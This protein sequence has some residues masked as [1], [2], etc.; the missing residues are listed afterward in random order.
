MDGICPPFPILLGAGGENPRVEIFSTDSQKPREVLGFPSSNSVYAI[1][2]HLE[3]NLFA[4]GTKGGL[5]YIL[6]GVGQHLD[7]KETAWSQK[8]VQG[9]SILSVCWI[10]KDLLAVS[11]TAGRCFLWYLNT[12][13]PPQPL[14]TANGL[15][16]GLLNL[17]EDFLVGL[18]SGGTLHFWDPL[19]GNLVR[20]INIPHPPK[21]SGLVRFVHWP[22]KDALVFPAQK[23]CLTH[24]NIFSDSI[25]TMGAHSAEVYAITVEGEN[26]I[27]AGINDGQLKIWSSTSKKPACQIQSFKGIVS[28]EA[29]GVNQS[30][31][32]LIESGGTAGVFKI[33][34]NSLKLITRLAGQDYR[35]VFGPSLE[36]IKV[37][38]DQHR[39]A[40]VR[41]LTSQILGKN[42]QAP[43]DVIQNCYSRLDG[44]D[45]GHISLALQA[46]QAIEKKDIV[47]AIR[48]RLSLQNKLPHND[49]NALPSIKKYAD[50]LAKAWHIEEA[51]DAYQKIL[52]ID[53]RYPLDTKIHALRKIADILSIKSNWIIEPDIA[54]DQIIQSAEAIGKSFFGRF[55]IKKHKSIQCRHANIS[56][57]RIVKKYEQI[58]KEL[59][60]KGLPPAVKEKV[61]WISQAGLEKV[62]IITF[63]N[64][65]DNCIKGLQ[66]AL[67]VINSGLAIVAIPLILFDWPDIGL[68]GTTEDRNESALKHLADI[69]TKVSSNS[70]LAMIHKTVL[71]AL[72]RLVTE[73][74]LR[75]EF[76]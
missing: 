12:Q 22:A 14:E 9:A 70:Y 44:L 38:S 4:V 33:Q 62:N 65:N 35:V 39:L 43:P 11:D 68:D 71:Q 66:F 36:S 40:E 55:V 32:L 63:G 73:N 17:K 51:Y 56:A 18:S 24:Y 50:L 46:E 45:F 28:M 61:W 10:N 27:T 76:N 47:E 37:L 58:R 7:L 21:M 54:I 67:E 26:L 59:K 6:E 53:P 72:S 52:S 34:Q 2:I 5:I 31:V 48:I 8:L 1:D 23:G 69:I 75:K 16:C 25:I 29:I 42:N 13:M 19:R 64:G 41:Q 60:V 20:T 74:T 57:S 15:I 30:K 3:N 49:P